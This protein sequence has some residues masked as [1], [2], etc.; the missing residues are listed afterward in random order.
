MRQMVGFGPLAW[1]ETLDRSCGTADCRN[2]GAADQQTCECIRNKDMAKSAF[3]CCRS[4]C[5]RYLGFHRPKITVSEIENFHSSFTGTY[6]PRT[7]SLYS[8][9]LPS[10]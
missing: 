2:R 5:G 8:P 7:S 6:S 4:V 9:P 10:R 1:L 3:R